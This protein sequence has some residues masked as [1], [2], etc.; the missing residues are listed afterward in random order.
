[1]GVTSHKLTETPIYTLR[2]DLVAIPLSNGPVKPIPAGAKIIVVPYDH[3][4][5]IVAKVKEA[6]LSA[7][8]I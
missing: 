8:S 6:G 2:G 7:I 3:D 1:M 4:P 5:D